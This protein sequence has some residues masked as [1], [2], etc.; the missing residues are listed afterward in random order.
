LNNLLKRVESI[1]VVPT[2]LL[3]R[4]NRERDPAAHDKHV[5]NV[6]GAEDERPMATTLVVKIGCS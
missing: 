2:R 6:G 4:V 5:A 1:L 3:E